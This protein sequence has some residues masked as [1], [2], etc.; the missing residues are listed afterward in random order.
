MRYKWRECVGVMDRAESRD[1]THFKYCNYLFE[2]SV[3][4]L[5]CDYVCRPEQRR[6]SRK[7]S[8]NYLLLYTTE[9]THGHQQEKVNTHPK[10]FN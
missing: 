4:D 9:K 1:L 7:P 3:T 2:W 5:P 8:R 6:A 10:R